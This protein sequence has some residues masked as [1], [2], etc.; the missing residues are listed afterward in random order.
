MAV[1][2]VQELQQDVPAGKGSYFCN[3][4]GHGPFYVS[5]RAMY[6]FCKF[7]TFFLGADLCENL[8]SQYPASFILIEQLDHH[9]RIAQ[10]CE[11]SLD[12]FPFFYLCVRINLFCQIDDIQGTLTVP[13]TG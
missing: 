5:L 3:G 11:C 13:D 7:T 6:P 10:L 12:I 9:S 8:R 1:V 2:V 4:I